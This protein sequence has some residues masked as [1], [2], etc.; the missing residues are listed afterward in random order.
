MK[1]VFIA[2]ALAGVSAATSL[3]AWAEQPAVA[4]DSAVKALFT[5]LGLNAKKVNTTPLD[6]VVE[7]ITNR[8]VF[9][10][11]ED[12]RYLFQG[13]LVDVQNKENLTEAALS[14]VRLEGVEQYKDS[15][16]VY[17][18][19]KEKGKITVFTD[20][21]CGYCRK[22]HRELEDYLEAGIT[23][24]YLGFPRGGM[25]SQGYKDLM[26]V[27]CAEDQQKALTDAK[28]G[29]TPKEVKQC[30]APV[31][32]HYQLGQSFGISGTP[33]IILSDG[34]MIPGYQPAAAISVAIDQLNTKS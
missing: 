6:G 3:G 34:S 28:A 32:E 24:Q 21:T 19:D 20:I 33:A 13:T 26:N 29:S 5:Q 2:L 23:V 8:G 11:S 31:A 17:K 10:A 14:G 18:A 27:W 22:L 25:G 9:Y 15:M 7:V 30:N 1:K 16:I 4:S 12:G